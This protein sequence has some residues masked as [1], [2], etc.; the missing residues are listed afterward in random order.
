MPLRLF[1]MLA[2]RAQKYEAQ[3]LYMFAASVRTAVW[4]GEKDFEKFSNQLSP[5]SNQS[6]KTIASGKDLSDMGVGYQRTGDQ[7][8]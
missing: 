4:A 3:F 1:R 8:A 7:D 2:T 5:D 6:N